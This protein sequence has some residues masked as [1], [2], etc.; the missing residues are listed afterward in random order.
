MVAAHQADLREY[1]GYFQDVGD[2][3]LVGCCWFAQA[4]AVSTGSPAP[5]CL[6]DHV[7]LRY[8]RAVRAANNAHLLQN[9]ELHFSQPA[10]VEWQ[11][12]LPEEA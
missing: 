7:K 4:A 1:L 12:A 2:G 6:G 3:V 10:L 5:K 9:A 11:P 8:P